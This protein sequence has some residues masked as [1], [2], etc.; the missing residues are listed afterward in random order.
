MIRVHIA[1]QLLDQYV[2]NL[3]ETVLI[4]SDLRLF[5]DLIPHQQGPIPMT[6]LCTDIPRQQHNIHTLRLHRSLKGGIC[7]SES[8]QLV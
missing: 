2:V 4:W 8:G 7:N 3:V 1:P 5:L 6:I